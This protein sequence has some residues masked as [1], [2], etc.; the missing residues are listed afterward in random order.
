MSLSHGNLAGQNFR[1]AKML[2]AQEAEV[3]RHRRRLEALGL[4][5]G[6]HHGSNPRPPACLRP[7]DKCG[8]VWH[9]PICGAGSCHPGDA[10]NNYCGRCGHV[11][12]DGVTDDARLRAE[13]ERLTGELQRRTDEWRTEQQ[14]RIA[15]EQARVAADQR[16]EQAERQRDATHR[17]LERVPEVHMKFGVVGVVEPE[18]AACADWCYAC[19][20][21]RA[22]AAVGRVRRLQE[23]TIASSCR[24]G[25][26]Q[27]AEDTLRVLDAEPPEEPPRRLGQPKEAPDDAD[28]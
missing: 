23:M 16:A 17:M 22:E 18:D 25:A 15:A 19:R 14:T 21:E 9:C 8:H 12:A 7:R 6:P 24:A 10:E 11:G 5:P 26:I 4:D 13:L 2:L 28:L 1:L 20:I 3:Q 27:Q